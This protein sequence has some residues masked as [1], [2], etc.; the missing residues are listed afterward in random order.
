MTISSINPATEDVLAEFQAMTPEQVNV[1]WKPAHRSLSPTKRQYYRLFACFRVKE[2]N[3]AARQDSAYCS[4]R[5]LSI[6]ASPTPG[7]QSR[8]SLSP[9]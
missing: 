4:A 3:R 9:R 8:A 5:N 2:S 1:H 7:Q 6:P